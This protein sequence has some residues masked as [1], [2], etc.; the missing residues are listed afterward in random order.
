MDISP[1]SRKEEMENE[2]YWSTIQLCKLN[3]IIKCFPV[4][5]FAEMERSEFDWGN[6][7]KKLNQLK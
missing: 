3:K 1:I 5:Y 2:I 6:Q 4:K 7:L